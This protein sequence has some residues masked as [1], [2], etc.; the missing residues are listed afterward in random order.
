MLLKNNDL[1]VSISSVMNSD[2]IY[3][4]ENETRQDLMKKFDMRV[5]VLPILDR[6]SHLITIVQSLGPIP[7]QKA[8]YIRAR[9]PGRISIA[10]GG[11]DFTSYEVLH[12]ITVENSGAVMIPENRIGNASIWSNVDDDDFEYWQARTTELYP[13]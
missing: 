7:F 5:K 11:T 9:A 2:F 8:S 13:N 3:A 4:K 6:R 10:G 1:D 12:E